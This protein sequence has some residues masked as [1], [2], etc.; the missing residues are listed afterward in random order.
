MK[1]LILALL[2]P[3]GLIA[4]SNSKNLISL[5]GGH[6]FMGSGDIR[7]FNVGFG[8]QKQFF[9]HFA[10][11]VNV[12]A[13]SA[14]GVTYFGNNGGAINS[15]NTELRMAT[16]GYQLEVLPVL[17]IINRKIKLSIIAGPVLRR[18]YNTKPNGYGVSYGTPVNMLTV[19]YSRTYIENSIG[20]T[21]QIEASIRLGQKANLGGRLA[22]HTYKRDL[23][24]YF[25]LVFMHEI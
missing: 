10:L 2:L 9:R 20:F 4:Q 22:G 8:F 6:T 1:S 23:N 15:T 21:G 14:S 5:S 25:P 3:F 24:W 17:P 19:N 18:Q 16:T 13:S 11:E 12:R 7:G